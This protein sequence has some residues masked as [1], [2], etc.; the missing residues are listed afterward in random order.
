MMRQTGGFAVYLAVVVTTALFFLVLAGQQI[1][2]AALDSGRSAALE[3]QAFHAADGGLE[4]GLGRL[5]KRFAPFALS[6]SVPLSR[7]REARIDIKRH[8]SREGPEPAGH[9][10]H[11]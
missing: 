11:P 6:Y 9:G 4:R 5:S 8:R 2:R 7:H 1:G 10:R 3:T